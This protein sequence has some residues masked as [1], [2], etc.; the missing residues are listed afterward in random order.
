MTCID[1]PPWIREKPWDS[2]WDPTDYWVAENADGI[3]VFWDGRKLRL[4]KSGYEVKVQ[5]NVI[6]SIFQRVKTKST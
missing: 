2:T 5:G 1:V 4:R 3:R 6:N